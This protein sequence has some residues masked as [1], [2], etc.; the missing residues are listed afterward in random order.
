MKTL[1]FIGTGNLASAII[2]GVAEARLV[3]PENI[4]IYDID[5]AKTAALAERFGVIVAADPCEAAACEA[6]VCAVKPKD[7]GVLLFS[8]SETVREKGTLVI[9]TAAGKPLADLTAD[10][11]ADAP[12]VRIMPNINAAV[13]AAMTAY[14]AT[15]AVTE[16]QTA[17]VADFCN[18]F[19]ECV[20]LEERLF[21]AFTAVAGSAPA[22]VYDFID[23]LAFAG[24]KNGLPRD[25]AL[26]IAAQTVLGSAKAVAE[27]GLHPAELTDRVCS[28]AG[29][30]VEGVAALRELGFDNAVITA[31]DRTVQKD[32]AMQKK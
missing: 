26:K 18:C 16:E 11:Y 15:S 31:V 28:P 12:V 9:S 20:R 22:F 17:F 32:M 2:K 7:M 6:A 19:G 4:R 13:G 14:C 1:G 25:L 10:L 30:T 3:A 8:I 21:S 23:D 29:T 24:V 5:S 27:M